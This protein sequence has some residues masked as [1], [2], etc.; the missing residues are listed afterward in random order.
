VP[1]QMRR[2]PEYGSIATKVC[3]KRTNMSVR[4]SFWEHFVQA[5]CAFLLDSFYVSFLSSPYARLGPSLGFSKSPFNN[6]TLYWHTF[7]VDSSAQI[8]VQDNK[9]TRSTRSR[10][11]AAFPSLSLGPLPPH[12][13]P[14]RAFLLGQPLDCF[15]LL[16]L[17]PPGQLAP[18]LSFGY[19]L[20]GDAEGILKERRKSQS[21]KR[22][23]G[24]LQST[25]ERKEQSE[26]KK[27]RKGTVRARMK[28]K[29]SQSTKRPMQFDP[30]GV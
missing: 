19:P 23:E 4:S 25:K 22:R 20:R 8:T 1:K 27:E 10:S 24:T 3:Q 16:L 9:P 30:A 17:L 26:H 28:R 21:K 2:R 7:T 29:K 12:R 13:L 6:D 14:E 11:R 5:V 15:V 18:N